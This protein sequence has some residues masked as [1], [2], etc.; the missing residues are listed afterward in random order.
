MGEG[1]TAPTTPTAPLIADAKGALWGTRPR[2]LFTVWL[3][4][5]GLIVLIWLAQPGANDRTVALSTIVCGLSTVGLWC[6]RVRLS[7]TLARWGAS[8]R[9]KFI[10]IG[11]V[12]AAWVETVFWALEKAFHG[13]GVAASPNLAVDL[14]V[15]MPWYVMMV[16]LLHRVE[17]THRYSM[18]EVLLL[19]GVYELGA[20][21]VVGPFVGG[22][23]SIASLP[24]ALLLLPMFVV[25]YSFMVLPPSV[26]LRDDLDRLREERGPGAVPAQRRYAYALLPLLGLVP[27]IV[28]GLIGALS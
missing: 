11:S 18:Y 20:D 3:S 8:P 7:R 16:A 23:F 1:T 28:L 5:V 22:K 6:S 2:I 21:G 13:E 19:G 17:T 10:L 26:L 9:A 24:V 15:T 27:Y 4:L 14:L 25:V 12:G